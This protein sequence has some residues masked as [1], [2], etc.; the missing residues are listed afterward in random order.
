MNHLHQ[1]AQKVAY[2]KAHPTY[3]SGELVN[4]DSARWYVET[5]LNSTYAFPDGKYILTLIDSALL[6]L[7]E[8]DTKLTT[9]DGMSALYE[10]CY[11]KAVEVAWHIYL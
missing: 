2:K 5:I 8:A 1:P 10:Q 3:K 4:V 11:I 6:Y 7:P 9:E